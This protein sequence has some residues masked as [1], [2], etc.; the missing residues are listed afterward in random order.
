MPILLAGTT[1]FV[2]IEQVSAL[3]KFRLGQVLLYMY[4]CRKSVSPGRGQH[5]MPT[6]KQLTLQLQSSYLN[7]LC[8]AAAKY[9]P[10]IFYIG[11][12]LVQ[13]YENLHLHDFL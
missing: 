6:L 11:L 4:M 12:C 2:H 9:K 1:E 3:F 13:Y 10:L 7:G 5:I 8:L